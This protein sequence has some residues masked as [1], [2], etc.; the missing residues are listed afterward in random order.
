MPQRNRHPTDAHPVA[1]GQPQSA[2][3]RKAGVWILLIQVY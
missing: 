2:E 3:V 1:S